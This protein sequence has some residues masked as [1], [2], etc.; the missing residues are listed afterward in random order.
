MNL[1]NYYKILDLEPNADLIEIKKAYRK[2]ALKF[3]P[4]VCGLPDAHIL[5]IEV[6]EAFEFLSDPVK[7][8]SYDELLNMND[9]DIVKVHYQNTYTY[10]SWVDN[11]KKN[12]EDY[13]KMSYSKYKTEVVDEIFKTVKETASWGC[14][15]SLALLGF[16]SLYGF[17]VGLREY[18]RNERDDHTFYLG[19]IFFVLFGIPGVLA[20]IGNLIKRR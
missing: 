11:A 7:R 5:F 6:N 19:L 4:D 8:K 10:E 15:I 9:F 3:H 2:K 14:F 12:A 1:K 18:L 13:S 17:F 20:I 16:L